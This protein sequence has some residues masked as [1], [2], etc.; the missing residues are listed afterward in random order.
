MELQFTIWPGTC[1]V[2]GESVLFGSQ[3]SIVVNKISPLTQTLE[4]VL[5]LVEGPHG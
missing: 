4:N 2:F 5:V 3:P 1:S